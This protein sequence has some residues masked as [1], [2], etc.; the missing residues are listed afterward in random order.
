ML[1]VFWLF[2]LAASGAS[3]DSRPHGH[4]L[5]EGDEPH[6]V[7]VYP[8]CPFVQDARGNAFRKFCK[9]HFKKSHD[10]RSTTLK[11]L[12]DIMFFEMRA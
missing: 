6:D 9:T 5:R 12:E 4:P 7:V 1:R 2:A 8:L 3:S 10:P 11:R